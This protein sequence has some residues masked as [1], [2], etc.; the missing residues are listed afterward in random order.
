MLIVDDDRI[1]ASALRAHLEAEHYFVAMEHDAAG[2]LASLNS[3]ERSNHPFQIMITDVM[4]PGASGLELVRKVRTHHPTVVPLVITG[5]GTIES[6]VDAIRSGAL[7]YLTKPIVDED[8]RLTLERALHQHTLLAENSSLRSQLDHRDAL[9]S[10]VGQDERMSKAMQLVET[11]ASTKVTVLIT[12]ESGT[13]KSLLAR[14]IHRASPRAGKPLIEMHCGSIPESLL[15][16]ELFGHVRGA[17]TGAT[18]D[19]QGRFLAADGGTIFIDEINSAS[20]ALQTRLLRVLQERCI[21]PVG[22]TETISIDVRVVLATNEPLEALVADA[23]FR[24]DLYYRINVVSI[25]LPPLRERPDD[26]PLLAVHFLEK[27]ALRHER[28]ITGFTPEAML[29]LQRHSYP[30][31]VRELENIIERA[32]VLTPT[33]FIDTP[34]LP[35]GMML[36]EPPRKPAS[37]AAPARNCWTPM[38]LAKALEGPERDIL[39]Q[40]LRANNWNRQKTAADL[41]INRTTLYKKMRALGIDRLAG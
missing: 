1:V 31:N 15:E 38:P 34:Q 27:H 24:E 30:G 19:K 25:D 40:T 20:P 6:A 35:Q 23:S 10:I 26:I 29:A 28:R 9:A 3:A 32:V 7:D 13:G 5:F 2:A 18:G 39:L 12:G 11:V 22:S 16:S 33:S 37:T 41:Q 8:L 21:E 36:H 17:F 4:M 14:A